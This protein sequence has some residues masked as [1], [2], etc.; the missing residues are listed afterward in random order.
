[1]N[2]TWLADQRLALVWLAALCVI[3]IVIGGI[4]SFLTRP[5]R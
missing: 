1:M 3:A 5:K 2:P 4:V